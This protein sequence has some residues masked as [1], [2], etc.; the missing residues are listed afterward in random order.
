MCDGVES[1]VFHRLR[2]RGID[3]RNSQVLRRSPD[4][5]NNPLEISQ[6][7]FVTNLRICHENL[8]VRPLPEAILSLENLE[9]S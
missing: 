8:D 2:V 3:W 7:R 9:K 1:Y 6:Q 4:A 5:S